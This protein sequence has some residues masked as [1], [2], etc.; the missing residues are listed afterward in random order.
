MRNSGK[1]LILIELNEINFDVVEKYVVADAGRFPALAKLLAGA[2]VRTTSEENYEQLEP[3]IQWPSVHTGCTF[4]EHGIFRLGDVV[5]KKV[6]Q[7]FEQLEQAGCKVG[8]I[9]AMNAE[10]RLTSPAYFVPDPWT[11]TPSDGSW[12]SRA[13]TEAVSQAVND[14]AQ[15]KIT[16]K[17]ALQVALALVRFARPRNYLR[18]LQLVLA[19]RQKSWLKPLVLDLLLHDVHWSFFNAKR[20]DFSTLF[21]NAG[22][23]IQHHYFFNAEPLRGEVVNKNPEWYVKPT[24]DP[25]ADVLSLYDLIV[26]EYFSRTDTEVILATGL[27]QKP[28]DRLKFYYRLNAHAD[29]LHSLGIQFTGVYPR[30][31]RDFLIEFD[32]EAQTSAAH[33]VLSGVQV[34]TDGRALFGEIDNRGKSLF[35]TLTY[36]DEITDST[37]YVV[38]GNSKRLKPLVS[39]VAIKNGM[40][41]S[42]G[43]AF[44]TNGVQAHAPND[45]AHVSSIGSAI[46]SY[47]GVHSDAA[48]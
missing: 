5:G 13:L 26:R 4:A 17:S 8:A 22:A 12:W 39:F 29:F 9:S 48:H 15:A 45:M 3:W 23:H 33:A 25:V 47:F 20:P 37:E 18:Y 41:Q 30:M 28:Y 27:A 40:H 7:I 32:N 42:Q 43:F 19:S 10:N 11:Q 16:P 46:L 24:D 14:N 1:R 36:P 21:L 31:T 6:P 44:F 34:K 2:R 35:V 38:G